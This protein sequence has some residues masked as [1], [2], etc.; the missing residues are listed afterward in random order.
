MSTIAIPTHLKT[1]VSTWCSQHI[2]PL[3]SYDPGAVGGAGWTLGTI[4]G[5]KW[6]LAVDDERIKILFIL[7]FGDRL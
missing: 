5:Q 3:C 2:S 7:T 4:G 6:L 1:E